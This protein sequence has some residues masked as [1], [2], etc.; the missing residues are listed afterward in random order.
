MQ[1][2]EMN[3][4]LPGGSNPANQPQIYQGGNFTSTQQSAGRSPAPHQGGSGFDVKVL[5]RIILQHWITVLLMAILGGLGGIFYIQNA[6]PVYQ[7][8]AEL[9]MNVRRPKVINSDVLYEDPSSQR[10]EDVIFNT[11]F[12]KF[13]SPAM[14]RLAANEYLKRYPDATH[15]SRGEPITQN[16]LSVWVRYVDWYKDP[17]A[18]IVTVSFSSSDPNFAAQLVNVVSHCAGELMMQENRAQSDEA[19]KWLVLQAADQRDVVEEVENELAQLREDLKLDSIEQQ[20]TALGH[21]LVMVSEEREALFSQLA[22]RETVYEFI[23]GLKVSEDGLEMLPSGLPKEA[24]LKD[25]IQ[26]WRAAHDNLL[27]VADRYTKLHPEYR[28]AEEIEVRSRQRLDRYIELS[29]KVMENEIELLEKQIEQMDTRIS[30]MKTEAVSLEQE[31]TSGMQKVQR[32]ERKRQAADDSYQAVLRRME[33]ARLSADE[34]MAFTKVIRTAKVPRSPV[35]PKRGQSLVMSVMLGGMAGAVLSLLMAFWSDKIGSVA[36]LKALGVNIITTIPSQKKADSRLEL[37]TILL[38]DK[39]NPIVEVFSSVNAMLS[40]DRYTDRSK[41][42]LLCSAG[43]GEGK[44]ISACNLAISSAHNGCRT[45]LIDCDLRRPQINNIFNIGEDH[46][47]LIDW[48]ADGEGLSFEDLVTHNGTDNLDIISSWPN[49]DITPAELLGREK[50]SELL[51]WARQHYDRIVI[52]S[53][54][55]GPVGDAQILA[56]YADSVILVARIGATKR[57]TLRYIIT[58]FWDMDVDLLGCIA[59]D[60]PHSLAGMFGGGEGYGYGYGSYKHY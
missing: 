12:A 37:A 7:A 28:K 24:E 6:I 57:R 14:E 47:S 18:N 17:G 44:T 20:K 3:G 55:L 25:M 4:S 35:S 48:L 10:D 13:R 59:N 34:N 36:D 16:M 21:S 38:R 30:S 58:R 51:A 1:S 32:L 56:N 9:E 15:T 31:L 52:D 45:L 33:E 8:Q 42:V 19:V 40:S 27:L 2:D 60:V 39:F 50:L 23:K 29:T 49:K 11:R 5:L 46:P 26:K 43:P 22:S 53:P 41:M 54:P